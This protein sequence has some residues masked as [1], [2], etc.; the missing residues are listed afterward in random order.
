[1]EKGGEDAQ[2]GSWGE[3]PGHPPLQQENLSMLKPW[4]AIVGL[5]GRG[6]GGSLFQPEQK[7]QRSGR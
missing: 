3:G 4:L 6:R 2:A 5:E 7:R 1:M